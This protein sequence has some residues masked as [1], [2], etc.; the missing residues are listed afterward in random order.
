MSFPV[1]R[2]PTKP[3]R[4]CYVCDE[5]IS[6]VGSTIINMDGNKHFCDHGKVNAIVAHCYTVDVPFGKN[7]EA[8]SMGA[9][10]VPFS[11]IWY[12]PL[13]GACGHRD[14]EDMGF[15][16]FRPQA[17]VQAEPLWAQLDEHCLG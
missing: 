8:K 13:G 12:I 5:P 2:I 15:A 17:S 6:N 9:K 4:R 1:K 10:Y 16:V 11:K 14:F 7:G 3:R